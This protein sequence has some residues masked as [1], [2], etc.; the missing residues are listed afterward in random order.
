MDEN[1]A[2]SIANTGSL[3]SAP[4]PPPEVKIRTMRSDLESMAKSGG[5]MPHFQSVQVS[6][7]AM[8]RAAAD[9]NPQ[10]KNQL[11]MAIVIFIGLLLL[12]GGGYLIS[13]MFMGG[14]SAQQPNSQTP[15]QQPGTSP[16]APPQTS[17]SGA[18]TGVTTPSPSPTP[19][20]TTAFTHASFFKTAPDQML[21]V[22]FPAPG[23]VQNATDLETF[24]QRI[25]AALSST[26]TKNGA[27]LTEINAKASDGHDL[28]AAEL[29]SEAGAGVIDPGVLAANFN[30]DITFFIY[31]GATDFWPGYI[32]SL[33]QGVTPA[34]MAT[35]IKKLEFSPSVANFFLTS[36][37][38]PA[39][40]GFKDSTVSG[41]A[42]RELSF[43]GNVAAVITY[44]WSGNY[45]ILSASPAGFASAVAK[46]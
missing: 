14:G 41:V 13:R 38:T 8:E 29:L 4:P 37:G 23:V 26:S 20:A 18:P 25:N 28:S 17:P 34:S 21:V 6:G 2:E 3:P 27:I 11:L 40:G 45:L 46:L 5:G 35:T 19:V 10:K 44:G 22:T 30:P 9:A 24:S 39:S 36:E 42:V 15:S 12:G 33:K 1:L 31:R 32:L 7:L 16:T 43:G